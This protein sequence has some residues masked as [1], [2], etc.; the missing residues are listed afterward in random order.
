MAFPETY[1]TKLKVVDQTMNLI[2]AL[3]LIVNFF[4]AFYDD[5]MIIVDDYK[6]IFNIKV[7]C[8]SHF[9]FS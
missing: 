3:D 6:V 7:L 2:F 8:Q 9:F 1:T 5:E 4:R